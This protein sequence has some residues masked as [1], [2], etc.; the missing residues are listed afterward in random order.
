MLY[1]SMALEFLIRILTLE[2]VG[3]GGGGGGKEGRKPHNFFKKG[4]TVQ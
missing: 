4:R 2:K 1:H 3:G